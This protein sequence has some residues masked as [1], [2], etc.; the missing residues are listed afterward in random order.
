MKYKGLLIVIAGPSGAGKGTIYYEVLR[1][2]PDIQK[3]VSV[4]TRAPRPGE[5]DGVHYHFRSLEEYQD[6]SAKGSFLETASVY[7]NYYGTPKAPV[8]NMLAEGRDVMFEV[9]IYG[10]RQIKARYPDCVMIFVMTPDFAVLEQRLRARRTESEDA[11]SRRISSAKNE[12]SQYDIFDYIVFNDE[13]EASVDTV[14]GII[15]AERS[16][17]RRNE[18]R[19]RALLGKEIKRP[20]QK[21]KS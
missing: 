3:S 6:M 21:N 8:F 1:R 4:T 14:I 15:D 10:A 13:A 5:E 18:D 12:L 20:S 7:N 17:V 19:I 2:R 16:R 11:L 9:D